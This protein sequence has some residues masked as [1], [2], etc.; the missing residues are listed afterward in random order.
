MDGIFV[1][2]VQH[3]GGDSFFSFFFCME[4]AEGRVEL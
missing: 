2:T 4:I 1:I 3:S